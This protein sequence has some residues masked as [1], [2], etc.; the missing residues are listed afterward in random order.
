MGN[1]LDEVSVATPWERDEGGCAKE[2][3][4]GLFED[5]RAFLTGGDFFGEGEGEDFA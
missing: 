4:F 3:A 1:A 2:G 5:F